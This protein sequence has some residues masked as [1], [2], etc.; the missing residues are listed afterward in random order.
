VGRPGDLGHGRRGK[1]FRRTIAGIPTR[2]FR[3]LLVGMATNAALW[4]IAVDPAYTS[5]WGRQHWL[6]PLHHT[7]PGTATVHHA[8]AVYALVRWAVLL[9]EVIP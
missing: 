8:A 7:S 3:D 1:R 6:A 2:R 4:V 5:R 9:E